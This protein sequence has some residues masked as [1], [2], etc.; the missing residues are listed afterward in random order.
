MSNLIPYKEM[1][2]MATVM[3]PLFQKR[4][5]D[6]LALMLIAQAEGLH[7]AV[8]A[9]EYDIIQGRPA[10]NSRATLS[11]FQRAGG[12]IK[13]VTR[14][15]DQAS[16]QFEHPQGGKLVVTWTMARAQQAGL[17]G[18]DSWRKYP[19]QMLAARVVAEGVRAVF[20]ACLS[21]MYTVEEVAD[22]DHGPMKPADPPKEVA[23]ATEAPSSPAVATFEAKAKRSSIADEVTAY[24]T[25]VVGTVDD[26]K[27]WT[28]AERDALEIKALATEAIKG[29][30]E[31]AHKA[32]A[33]L[34]ARV[35]YYAHYRDSNAQRAIAYITDCGEDVESLR[36]PEPAQEPKTEEKDYEPE[37]Y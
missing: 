14:A 29:T 37:L 17:T 28:A 2:Q 22:F 34:K 3:G 10:I 23:P 12:T 27:G 11:R 26:P 32:W 31:S 35:D 7:P 36:I 18:K 24:I 6:L 33:L 16:A 4:P 30:E 9:Q 15:D 20:P 19:A 25:K 21:G 8:A 5:T 1:E 13:W